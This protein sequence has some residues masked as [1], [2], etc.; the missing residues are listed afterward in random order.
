[1]RFDDCNFT[2]VVCTNLQMEIEV[3]DFLITDEAP[4]AVHSDSHLEAASRFPQSEH[5]TD[6]SFHCDVKIAPKS[7]D[8]II[9]D[10]VRAAGNVTV[11]CM[12]CV[13]DSDITITR[14]SRDERR[15][16]RRATPKYR[17]AHASRERLRVSLFNVAF[18]SLRR[19]LPTLPP[20]RKLSKIEVLRLAICYIAYLDDVLRL[21]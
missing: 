16:R 18:T 19:L 14:L 13:N 6:C 7:S 17:S 3:K 5:A 21:R 10:V 20:D 2:A 9:D 12:P 11:S 15:R 1:M 8:Y 4:H